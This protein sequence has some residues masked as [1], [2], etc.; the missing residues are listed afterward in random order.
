MNTPITHNLYR[1]IRTN[2]ECIVLVEWALLEDNQEPYVVY[3]SMVD[4]K[5][6]LCPYKEFFDGR[7]SRITE[8]EIIT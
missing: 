6:W 3:K 7:Y 2:E 8:D 1:H 5:V 4:G